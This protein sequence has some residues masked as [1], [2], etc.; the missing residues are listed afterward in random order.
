MSTAQVSPSAGNKIKQSGKAIVTPSDDTL[1]KRMTAER[2]VV[3]E[4]L[5]VCGVIGTTN[6]DGDEL[7]PV[8]DCLNW[9]QD[10]QRALRRDDDTFRPVS[11]LLGK[12]KVVQQKLLPLVMTCRYDTPMI[13]TIVKILVILTKP[14]GEAAKKAG[15]FAIDTKKYS[16]ET[17][18]EQIKLRENALA[19][20]EMLMEFKR[21]MTHHPSHSGGKGGGLFSVFVSLLAEPISKT[22]SARSDMDHLTIELVLHLFRNLLT[23]EPLIKNSADVSQASSQLHQ[24]LVCLF[25]SELVLEILLVVAQDMESR[26]N[27][28]YNLLMMELL[29]LLLKSQDPTA[30]ARSI[31]IQPFV[32]GKENKPETTSLL[33]DSLAKERQKIRAIAT[34]SRH[35]NFGGTLVVRKPDG[36]RQYLSAALLGSHVEPPGAKKRRNRKREAFVGAGRTMVSHTRGVHAPSP[37]ALKAQQTIHS[38]CE[39]F[40]ENCYGPLMKSIKNEFRR[41]SVRLEDGDTVVFFRIVWFFAQWW[42]ICRKEGLGH[43]IFTMDVF[44]FKLVLGAMD[45]YLQQKKYPQ[46]AQTT[47]L[48]S[49]MMHL[50]YVMYSSK[51]STENM[52][53]LGLMDTL[54]YGNE[55]LDRLP[56]LLSGWTPGTSTREYLCDLAEVVHMTLKLLETNATACLKDEDHDEHTSKKEKKDAKKRDAIASMKANAAEFDVNSYLLR[57]LISN[58]TVAMYT[59]LLSQYAVNA[60]HVNHRILAFLMRFQKTKIVVH[61]DDDNGLSNPLATRTVTLEPMLFNI[62]MLLVLDQILNDTSIRREAD[63]GHLLSYCARVMASF[64]SLAA[65]NPLLY[66]ESLFRHAIPHRFCEQ[67]MNHYVIEEL[68]MIA[69]R[70]LLLEEERR[71]MEE[72]E[73]E[74]NDQVEE[75][76]EAGTAILKPLRESNQNEVDEG[77]QSDDDEIEWDDGGKGTAKSDP[78]NKRR[79]I[80]FSDS[81]S[82]DE[83]SAERLKEMTEPPTKKQKPST[84][85]L[86]ESSDDEDAVPTTADDV[87]SPTVAKEVSSDQKVDS[88]V[89][90]EDSVAE[91]AEEEFD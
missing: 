20:S 15:R 3:D 8:T 49:E 38:F 60:A 82:D 79:D 69:E 28:N 84:S 46:L 87:D 85:F 40:A 73:K 22:G 81:E 71:M 76:L 67:V 75:A 31:K 33:R 63:F 30:V 34:S 21:A 19:Q 24:E 17:I 91:S 10:L 11:L 26:E 58:Q 86:A 12:W 35:S 32:G 1:Y 43:L 78:K 44:S 53:A 72:E 62:Q 77:G 80:I 6:T 55:P 2:G 74:S 89:V 83:S 51:D 14:L 65:V 37:S 50:L 45:N 59:H 18:K 41:D 64:A 47:A 25:E 16:E 90:D 27:Q 68:R 52:M 9:L 39:R 48:Y 13:L 61:E 36:K 29:N 4:L 54:F 88:D 23:A 42:R 57:K 5:L 70:E 7:V 56:K 66:V